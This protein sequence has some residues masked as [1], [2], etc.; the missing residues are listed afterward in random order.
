MD[1]KIHVL[2]LLT[3]LVAV[4]LLVAHHHWRSSVS[5]PA[6]PVSVDHQPRPVQAANQA[7]SPATLLRCHC[8]LVGAVMAVVVLMVGHQAGRVVAEVAAGIV[9]RLG[10]AHLVVVQQTGGWHLVER[11]VV[12]EVGRKWSSR[13]HAASRLCAGRHARNA[14]WQVLAL[15]V[16]G[17]S[18]K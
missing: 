18:E 6:V 7:R 13:L 12:V 8:R 16:F 5:S 4:L 17:Q 2:G 15:A 1:E 3:A 10:V 11:V 9:G 14:G